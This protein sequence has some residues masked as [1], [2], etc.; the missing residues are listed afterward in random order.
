MNTPTLL[1]IDISPLL[2]FALTKVG[3]SPWSS[4]VCRASLGNHGYIPVSNPCSFFAV[5][6]SWRDLSILKCHMLFFFLPDTP[7]RIIPNPRAI[8]KKNKPLYV[9]LLYMYFLYL[10]LAFKKKTF[11]TIKFYIQLYIDSLYQGSFL[12]P[13]CQ[14]NSSAAFNLQVINNKSWN[15]VWMTQKPWKADF[16][17]DPPPNP[18]RSLCLRRSLGKSVS[19]YSKS[20]PSRPS[21]VVSF[22]SNA[23][24]HALPRIIAN[25]MNSA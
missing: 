22:F 11:P 1:L 18:A 5:D 7:H 13:T 25:A 23:L 24:V 19:I 21:T 4:F 10:F 8:N 20:A 9:L 14:N 17:R 3:L 16:M 6:N 12:R 2:L 15:P